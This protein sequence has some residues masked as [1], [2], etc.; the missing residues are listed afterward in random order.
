MRLEVRVQPKSSKEEVKKFDENSYKV[1]MYEPAVEGR[2]NKKLVEIL[3]DYFNV[4]K[5]DISILSGLK[6]RNKIVS[7]NKKR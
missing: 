2:A 5:S 1:Y 7:I 6:T 3:A 4:K